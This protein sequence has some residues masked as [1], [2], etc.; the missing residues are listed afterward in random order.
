MLESLLTVAFEQYV[1]DNDVNGAVM[2]LARGIEVTEE[3]LSIAVIDE[4]CSGAGHF[5][6]HPQ[7]LALMNSEY[8]YPA[9]FDRRGRDDWEADG[10]ADI[11]AAAKARAAEILDGH[12]PEVIPPEVDRELRRRFDI[13]L[14]ESE[15]RPAPGLAAGAGGC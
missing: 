12:W 8:L 15:M 5:L 11:R 14:P 7:T 1:I 4:V 10:G 3:T 2:R 6:G 9:L 13:L